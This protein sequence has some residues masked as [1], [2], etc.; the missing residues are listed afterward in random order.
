ME[1]SRV[2]YEVAKCLKELKFSGYCSHY[3]IH[4]DHR[5]RFKD[6]GSIKPFSTDSENQLTY[7][8]M[9]S[10]RDTQQHLVLVP[11][12]SLAAKWIRENY[13][14]T[15]EPCDFHPDKD[16]DFKT[17]KWSPIFRLWKKNSYWLEPDDIQKYF[18]TFEE[19]LDYG[20]LIAC[21][22]IIPHES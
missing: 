15:I 7:K 22:Y 13:Y 5:K 21:K 9:S 12:L 20:I 3:Y 4:E 18:D 10:T 8:K 17:I 2:S 6:D 16:D 19:A 14:I 11:T 1:E